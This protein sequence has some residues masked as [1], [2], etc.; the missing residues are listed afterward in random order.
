[1]NNT[2]PLSNVVCITTV[3]GYECGDRQ[4]LYNLDV[5]IFCFALITFLLAVAIILYRW[6][7]GLF[8]S[9]FRRID[10][11]WMP[12]PVD[13]LLLGWCVEKLLRTCSYF[14]QVIHAPA[15]TLAQQIPYLI[16]TSLLRLAM[17]QFVVGII[18]Y[19]PAMFICRPRSSKAVNY[20][21]QV[22]SNGQSTV[23][24]SGYTL[25][26]PSTRALYWI[27]V[28]YSMLWILFTLMIGI[29]ITVFQVRDDQESAKHANSILTSASNFNFCVILLVSC[30]YC[31]GFYRIM[32]TH[33]DQSINSSKL[34]RGE[35]TAA[36]NFRNIFLGILSLPLVSLILAIVQYAERSASRGTTSVLIFNMVSRHIIIYSVIEWVVFFFIFRNSQ[37]QARRK[38]ADTKLSEME[39]ST[40]NNQKGCYS[41]GTTQHSRTNQGQSATYGNN[42]T[43]DGGLVWQSFGGSSSSNSNCQSPQGSYHPLVVDVSPLTPTY[44]SQSEELSPQTP[45]YRENTVGGIHSHPLYK[46]IDQLP[47]P[48]F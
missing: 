30:Y 4:V 9:I 11:Y 48:R 24:Q 46:P 7:H 25:H 19:I 26:V 23:T 17:V 15:N 13:I 34:K 10:D 42:H 31:Y 32:R 36:R 20:V 27:N 44:D 33:A 38:N 47:S 45:N 1:M 40:K 6:Y 39:S 29:E 16:A 2:K 3:S 28:I 12:K 8:T 5:A 21:L 22:A 14:L 37:N 41:P 35:T 43:R 18:T